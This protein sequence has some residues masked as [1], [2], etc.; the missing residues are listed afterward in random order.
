MNIICCRIPQFLLNLAYRHEPA[1]RG[2]PVVLIG[3]D[4]QVWA[5]SPQAFES[6]VR[7]QMSVRQ[8]QMRCPDAVIKPLDVAKSQNEQNAF[9]ELA[10]KWEV[11]TEESGWGLAYIDLHPITTKRDEVQLLN[12]ELGQQIRQALG[13]ELA[14]CIG[15]NS[16]K[17]TARS[18]STLVRQGHMRLVE[19]AAQPRFLNP[20]PLSLLPLPHRSHQ[21]LHWLGITTLGQFAALPTPDVLQR[22]GTAGK[23]AQQWAKGKDDRPVRSTIRQR[24]Q[25]V[26]VEMEP[27]TGLLHLAVE[28]LFATLQPYLQTLREQLAGCQRLRL[29]LTFVEGDDQTISL[30]FAEPVSQEQR[31]K[32]A[33]TA[34]LQLIHWPNEL[35]KITI[36]M[37]ESGELPAQQL[38][39]F[40]ALTPEQSPLL[41]I[42]DKLAPKYGEI[43]YQTNPA[44]RTNPVAERRF[45]YHFGDESKPLWF[46]G[47]PIVV[48]TNRNGEPRHFIWQQ[49]ARAIKQI[50]Q[51]WYVNTEWWSESGRIWR[52]YFVLIAR[53]GLLAVIY[54]DLLDDSW[55]LSKIYG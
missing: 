9:L 44:N 22:F 37:L 23:T 47:T 43:F 40:S 32:A 53:D 3:A 38:S 2:K 42:M 24:F 4:E 12:K 36:A 28:T 50:Q 21:Q 49:R 33:I 14:P 29:K 15:C 8:A 35:S 34:Q 10:A 1:L 52:E 30:C 5:T 7:N 46:V 51:H 48:E 39:L 55:Y 11:P 6:G 45:A 31:L 18:A 41:A 20:L 19:K 13:K 54:H 17:F 26:A 25:P 27:P 16:S